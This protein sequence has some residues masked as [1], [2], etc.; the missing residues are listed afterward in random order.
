MATV[1]NPFG[2]NGRGGAKMMLIWYE[3]TNYLN[4]EG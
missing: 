1:L 4:F 2:T 3:F